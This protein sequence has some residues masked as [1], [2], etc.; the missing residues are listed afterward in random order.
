MYKIVLNSITVT[1]G[2]QTT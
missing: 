2:L 1:I